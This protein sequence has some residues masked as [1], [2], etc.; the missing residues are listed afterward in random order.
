MKNQLERSQKH[1]SGIAGT[2]KKYGF[3]NDLWNVVSGIRIPCSSVF[4]CLANNKKWIFGCRTNESTRNWR[5]CGNDDVGWTERRGEDLQTRQIKLGD[6]E[7]ETDDVD[8]TYPHEKFRNCLGIPWKLYKRLKKDL[9]NHRRECWET[10]II[11]RRRPGKATDVK[12]MNWL[13]LQSS[14]N[15]ADRNE[16]VTYMS[17]Q[18]GQ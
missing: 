10:R 7:I 3:Y 8:P 9:L 13:K 2:W 6:D 18:S 11:A 17:E 16:D 14:S 12:I 15:S 4:H 5:K 1:E